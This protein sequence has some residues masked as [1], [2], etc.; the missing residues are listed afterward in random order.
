M[1]EIKD[2]KLCVDIGW[3]P[4][5]KG[6]LK[7][8]KSAIESAVSG[9]SKDTY[10]LNLAC[11][12]KK[13]DGNELIFFG[14]KHDKADHIH[15]MGDNRTGAKKGVNEEI[16]VDLSAMKENCEMIF[17]VTI[18]EAKV[19]GQNLFAVENV[20]AQVRGVGS[21]KTY[22][23]EEE[24]FNKEDA[25][26]SATY[27]FAKVIKTESGVNVETMNQY[28]A[29]DKEVDVFEEYKKAAF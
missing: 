22:L 13:E 19:L 2:E 8:V 3:D 11:I 10:D 29:A 1:L 4:E 15:Y 20:F 9:V 16:R 23:R 25:K 27:V 7:E 21:E 24:A 5:Q 14:N 6:L 17:F 26:S 18:D 28:L 12:L